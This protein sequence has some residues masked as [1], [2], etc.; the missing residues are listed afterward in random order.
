MRNRKADGWREPRAG[1][2]L[3]GLIGVLA[4]P[5]WSQQTPAAAQP[6]AA[7]PAA[8]QPVA[9]AD[10]AAAVIGEVTEVFFDQDLEISSDIMLQG[11][12]ATETISFR[13]SNRWKL[14]RDPVV[15]IHFD[16][17]ES[18]VRERSS[19]TIW[20][21]NQGLASVPLTE[22]NAR[23]GRIKVR[24]PRSILYDAGYND[25]KFKV[26]QH[27]AD[28]CEDPF[29]PALWTR[30][31]LDS[32]IS[33]GHTTDPVE[34]ELANFPAPFFD[35]LDYGPMKIALAGPAELSADQLDAVGLVGF[36]FGRHADYRGVEV[37]APVEDPSQ[38]TSHL[39]IV[40]TADKNP[41]VARYVDRGALR[42]GVGTVVS[43]PNP[44]NPKY[45]VLVVTG[46]DA[47]GV[48]KAAE[49]IASDD[50]YEL[51]A[52]TKSDILDVEDVV[53]PESRRSPAA[54][55]FARSGEMAKSSLEEL[56]MANRTV[57]GFD[58]PPVQVPLRL[59]GD[60]QVQ[61]D[62]ARVAIDYAYAAGLDTRLSTMEI[63]LD[64]VTL[65]SVSLNRKEGEEKNRIWVDLP[66]ELMEPDSQLE[67]IFHLFPINFD[68][69]VYVNDKHIWATVFA[70]S[71]VHIARDR[72]AELPN[73]GLL[74][75]DLWPLNTALADDGLVV[76]VPDRATAADGS[77]AMHLLA[78]LGSRSA[79]VRPDFR[80]VAGGGAF[81]DDKGTQDI[82]LLVN[83]GA[84]TAYKS[85]VD[86]KLVTTSGD[87]D[88]V[89]TEDGK[90]V[91]EA[92]NGANIGTVEQVV[93]RSG[94]DGRT[95]L[96]VCSNTAA[97]LLELVHD[98]SNPSILGGMSGGLSVVDGG[99]ELRNLD[100]GAKVT[101]GNRTLASQ[102]K[103]TIRGSWGLL[104]MGVLISAVLLAMIVQGWASRRG[105]HTG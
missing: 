54:L 76:I 73:L 22:E 28:E 60:A 41:L 23:D 96:V 10:A 72:I 67:I 103:Q 7:Q 88:R 8:A 86:R 74:K 65:R 15:E 40:G 34:P 13:V 100:L 43:L 85:L 83:E 46:G 19:L 20:V 6:A 68:P 89:A 104:G 44:A 49:A 38:A 56:G 42:P 71:E 27:I 5:A 69:C 45:G 94:I 66:F 16:H 52:G 75:Y 97:G 87:L 47:I 93:L 30:V 84:H 91:L 101:L 33:F 48:L 1:L 24:V 64:D 29:D 61:I 55:P 9:P 32:N 31:S 37:A 77:A 80:V 57:R 98:L 92:R 36:A 62:G 95:A 50:R 53:P 105:G 102:L 82:V 39:L 81:A 3:T 78:E 35:P 59:E 12:T 14:L 11:I 21:N 26:V 58:S 90:K 18:L 79:T 25:L 63:R 99:A 17:S 4:A 70:S 51:L 2:L